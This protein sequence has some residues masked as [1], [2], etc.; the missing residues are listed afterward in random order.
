MLTSFHFLRP[1]GLLTFLPLIVLF[2]MLVRQSPQADAWSTICD[3]HLL[4]RLILIK[5]G[6]KRYTALFL[7][8]AAGICLAIALSGP[9]WSFISVPTYRSLQPRVVLLDMSET[10]LTK[11]VPPNRLDRAKFKLHDLFKIKNAGQF[12][13]IVYSGEPFVVSPLTDDAQTIEA[14]VDLL[15]PGIL[16]VSGQNLEQALEAAGNLIHEAGFAEGEILVLTGETP[17]KEAIETANQ[18][19]KQRIY[20][21]VIP[22][23]PQHT[24][25]PLFASLAKAGLGQLI[26][27][28]DTTKDIDLWLSSTRNAKKMGRSEQNEVIVW[29]DQGR[30]FLIP[31]LTFLLPVFQR[32]WLC[33]V[34]L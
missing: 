4:N 22:V 9:S 30:W 1:W 24:Y 11:D 33:R 14:T 5:G 23:M 21:S 6:K 32:N 20:T 18:L 34:N 8:F 31:A 26:P 7:F 16:P 17:H 2:L 10:M 29:R 19:A 28:T 12:A 25:Q 3:Q 13:L 15:T 27:F